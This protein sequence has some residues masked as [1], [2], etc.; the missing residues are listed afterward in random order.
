MSR[1]LG[2]TPWNKREIQLATTEK[3]CVI[4][5]SHKAVSNDNYPILNRA[6]KMINMSRYLWQQKYGIIA[7]GLDLCH[8]CDNPSCVNI[9][10]LF[11]GTR[12]ENLQDMV[13]K[14]RHRYGEKATGAKLD[15]LQVK[16]IL[17]LCKKKKSERMT[18]EE[19]GRM[20]HVNRRHICDIRHRKKWKLV[21]V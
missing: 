8:H 5:V 21:E 9:D 20:Y 17:L 18:D 3:G 11:L 1:K 4:C 12:K 19:I 13:R 2:S 7:Q 14:K 6:G 10:H 16:E 15:A